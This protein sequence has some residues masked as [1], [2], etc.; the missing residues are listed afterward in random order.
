[1]R[2]SFG[3][4]KVYLILSCLILSSAINYFLKISKY[5]HFPTMCQAMS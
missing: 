5:L 4:N 1:M 2:I 3:M